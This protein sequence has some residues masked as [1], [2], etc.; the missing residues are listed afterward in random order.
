MFKKGKWGKVALAS[1]LLASSLGIATPALAAPPTLTS[2]EDAKLTK[3][4]KA[5]P[6]I[7]IYK[8][9][10]DRDTYTFQ[11]AGGGTV[12][13]DHTSG[14]VLQDSVTIK[15][16]DEIPVI[17]NQTL[18]G[19]NVPKGTAGGTIPEGNQQAIV[20]ITIADIL[21]GGTPNST[22]DD[23]RFPHAGVYTYKV[24]E[25]TTSNKA[26]GAYIIRSQAEYTMRLYVTND[27]TTGQPKVTG[28]TVQRDKDDNGDDYTPGGTGGDNSD[29]AKKMDPTYPKDT[30][31]PK[32]N[33][34]NDEIPDAVE[35]ETGKTEDPTLKGDSEGRNVYGF[36]FTNEYVKGGRFIIQ[37]VTKGDYADKSKLFD[38][39]VELFDVGANGRSGIKVAYTVDDGNGNAVEKSATFGKDY[40][41]DEQGV[42]NTGQFKDAIVRFKAQI[43]DT[44]KISI[45]SI[46][47]ING[48]VIQEGLNAGTTVT[49]T[50]TGV[51]EYTASGYYWNKNTDTVAP[52]ATKGQDGKYT[53]DPADAGVTKAFTQ[54]AE[55]AGVTVGSNNPNDDN[56]HIT[57]TVDGGYVYLLNIYDDTAVTP[58]GIL[59]NNLP[60]VLMVGIPVVAFAVMFVN[61][62]RHADEIA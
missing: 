5:D 29:N 43:S 53:A 8:N 32:D 55:G 59:I 25:P 11:F 36:T 22:Q 47:D 13:A 4:I 49:V 48:Q 21:N 45:N 6:S 39:N 61:K 26:S 24:T 19:I 51:N 2:P 10:S 12:G 50:E 41:T 52:T 54:S 28:V 18:E 46:T 62:R 37:K 15:E 57:T 38:V 56:N 14:G 34:I 23:I 31:N 60:Y 16:N 7:T 40:T 27:E 42:D 20:Q 9:D 3:V 33:V 30:D 58:T 17:P 44:G 35:T 1:A